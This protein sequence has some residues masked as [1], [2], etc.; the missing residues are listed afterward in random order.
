M[1]SLSSQSSSIHRPHAVAAP[2][3]PLNASRPACTSSPT[4][5]S[6]ACSSSQPG[7]HILLARLD[8]AATS[9][10]RNSFGTCLN[11]ILWLGPVRIRRI[12]VAPSPKTTTRGGMAT[13][14]EVLNHAFRSGM[15]TLMAIWGARRSF[16]EAR[17]FGSRSGCPLNAHGEH[18]YSMPRLYLTDDYCRLVS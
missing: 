9:E 15:A 5:C 18:G 1:V 3:S 12:T 2:R 6:N 7:D 16:G 10:P 11:R 8:P 13:V 17:G 14:S 4:N